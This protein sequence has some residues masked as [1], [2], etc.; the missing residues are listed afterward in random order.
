IPVSYDAARPFNINVSDD[1]PVESFSSHNNGN[2]QG[3]VD[4][5]PY[6]KDMVGRTLASTEMLRPGKV[7]LLLERY[8]GKSVQLPAHEGMDDTAY[9]SLKIYQDEVVEELGRYAKSH[10]VKDIDE[11]VAGLGDATLSNIWKE[12]KTR[13]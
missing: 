4:M 11:V 5:I 6:L 13:L 1:G 8:A 10:S 9:G 2:P 7:R 3:T 12:I